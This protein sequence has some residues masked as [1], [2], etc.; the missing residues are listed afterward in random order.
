VQPVGERVVDRVDVRI[1]E[2]V[3][4]GVVDGRD[5]VLGRELLG[6]ATVTRRDRD[7]GR[8]VGQ[9]TRRLHHRDR[10]DAGGTE[11]SDS[12]GLQAPGA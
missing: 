3:L 9:L 12:N 11:D 5:L 4:V 10:R 2:Q 1:G 8:L 6:P 7:H